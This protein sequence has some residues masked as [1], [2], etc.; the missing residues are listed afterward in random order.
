MPFTIEKTPTFGEDCLRAFGLLW[1]EREACRD[2]LETPGERKV[3]QRAFDKKTAQMN[4]LL[5]AYNAWREIE[6]L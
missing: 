5:D 2:M 6:G 3:W 1:D 4:D